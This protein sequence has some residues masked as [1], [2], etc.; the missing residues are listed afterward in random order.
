MSHVRGPAFL[1]VWLCAAVSAADAQVA[2]A[3][4]GEHMV[5]VSGHRMRVVVRG[6]QGRATGS[7]IVVFEAGATNA[8]EVWGDIPARIATTAP[9]VAYDRAGLGR[10]EWDDAA[11]TPE[12]VATRLRR[13]LTGIGAEPPYVLVGYSWGGT[14]AR[15]FAGYHP[16][17][18]AGLVYVDPGPIV[19]QS[20]T[21][22]LA[23]FE[24]VGAGQ[25][26]YDALWSS[27]AAVFERLRPPLRAEFDVFRNLMEI[28]PSERDLRAVPQV[29]VVVLV[30]AK[31]EPLALPLP[32]DQ[33]LQFE[34]DVRHR[35]RLLNEWALASPRGTLVVSNHTG[36]RMPTEDPDLIVWA[37]HRV[38]SS[39]GKGP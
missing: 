6:L 9:V 26:G 29:P 12:H 39:I 17:D 34:A 14:L 31:Y 10:S 22:R 33:R 4:D 11:P 20:L 18:V 30:A 28:E 8:L 35:L 38:L 36:H 25:A 37:I 16:A 7:P 5:E 2:A 15:Y 21:E 23:P 13:L 27:M 19:T 1:I 24:A 32:Y 3:P